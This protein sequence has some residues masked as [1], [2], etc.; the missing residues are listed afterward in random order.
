MDNTNGENI[1]SE[2]YFDPNNSMISKP[3]IA[4]QKAPKLEGVAQKKASVVGRILR[5]QRFC[6]HD[7]PGIRTTVF[8]Q[9]CA[10]RCKWCHNPES[11]EQKTALMFNES[12]CKGCGLCMTKCKSDV[13]SFVDG[14]HKVDFQKCNAC[15]ECL[16]I[17]VPEA[18]S[19]HGKEE[20]VDEIVRQIVKDMDYYKSSGGGVTI[21]GGEPLRQPEFVMSLS[22]RCHAEGLTVFLDTCGFAT[23]SVFNEVADV[24][25]GF[26]YDV[27][28]IDPEEH[29]LWTGMGNDLILGNFQKAVSTGKTVRLRIILIEG[30]NDT[31]ANLTGLLALTKKVGFSGPIDIMPYHRMGAGKYRNMG[32]EY[33][34]EG[35]APPSPETIGRVKAFFVAAG[36][37]VTVYG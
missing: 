4:S 37:A 26:L 2:Y 11:Q 29:K 8:L 16:K 12:L 5:V 23:E 21:S 20:S 7:G 10:L 24:V 34:M 13:H 9:G 6:I 17:C 32:K 22:N 33:E 27:K 36:F 28:L 19:L 3:D 25:D 1:V 14:D 15:G 18:L 30:L 35:V 31:E